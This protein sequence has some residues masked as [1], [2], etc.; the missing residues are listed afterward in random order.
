MSGD[1]SC[2]KCMS[3][4]RKLDFQMN[5]G[6]TRL[7]HHNTTLVT[8]HNTGKRSKS[9][10][11]LTA[12][13]I[14]M[15][16]RSHA[17]FN[18]QISR[19]YRMFLDVVHFLL[20]FQFICTLESKNATL[21]D[22]QTSSVRKLSHDTLLVATHL[23]RIICGASMAVWFASLWTAKCG[24]SSTNS[25]SSVQFNHLWGPKSDMQ[26]YAWYL[27][28]DSSVS[29]VAELKMQRSRILAAGDCEKDR[30]VHS[31]TLVA[32]IRVQAVETSP[33]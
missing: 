12:C 18:G 17:S 2:V 30:L 27:G 1:V 15:C 5:P 7:I 24:P 23:E 22:E 31:T 33:C 16:G 20:V 32:E 14:R 26:W 9:H 28:V 25:M 6:N 10:Q 11:D 8:P 3:E 29:P 19:K 13:W 21:F 4:A